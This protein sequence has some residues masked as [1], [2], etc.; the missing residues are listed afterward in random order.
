MPRER[1]LRQIQLCVYVAGRLVFL[2][3]HFGARSQAFLPAPL[4][5][6]KDIQERER[7]I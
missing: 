5:F 7:C 4:Y 1:P 2:A 3:G 6:K